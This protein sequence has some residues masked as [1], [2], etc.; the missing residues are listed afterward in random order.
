[1]I[2]S[3]IFLVSACIELCRVDAD[4]YSRHLAGIDLYCTGIRSRRLS[5]QE[6]SKKCGAHADHAVILL[7][8][9]P[10]AVMRT[11]PDDDLLGHVSRMIFSIRPFRQRMYVN[12]SRSLY[13]NYSVGWHGRSLA[14]YRFLLSSPRPTV[15][16][17][18]SASAWP[19]TRT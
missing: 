8:C 10:A 16:R 12:A 6:G 3:D 14:N 19:R 4:I 7:S 9:V 17:G 5:C 2:S 11:L 1:M 15:F 13:S 18:I